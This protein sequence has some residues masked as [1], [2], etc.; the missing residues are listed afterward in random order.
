[1]S[2]SQSSD[3][4]CSLGVLSQI[5]QLMCSPLQGEKG[6]G[7]WDEETVRGRC[8][9]EIGAGASWLRVKRK[10]TPFL[11]HRTGTRCLKEGI[12]LCLNWPLKVVPNL[13]RGAQ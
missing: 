7:S 5:C 13:A 1:M 12:V 10:R 6:S 2:W 9:G 4:P 8:T 3:G 11:L